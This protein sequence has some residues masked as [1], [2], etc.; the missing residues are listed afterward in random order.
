MF[1]GIELSDGL[2]SCISG[3]TDWAF[4]KF[5]SSRSKLA[6]DEGKNDEPNRT[7]VARLVLDIFNCLVDNNNYF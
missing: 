5:T 3:A 2:E 1:E 4:G 7:E 6:F